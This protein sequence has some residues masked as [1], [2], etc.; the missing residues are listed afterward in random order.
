MLINRQ[1]ISFNSDT[2]LAF[3]L[4]NDDK[5]LYLVVESLDEVTTGKVAGV[6]LFRVALGAI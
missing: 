1:Q 2:K 3:A 6:Y 4:G 5:N